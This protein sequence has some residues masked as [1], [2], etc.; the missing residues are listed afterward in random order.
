MT[1]RIVMFLLVAAFGLAASGCHTVYRTS[2]GAAAGAV[3][4]AQKDY[5]DAKKADEWMKKNLW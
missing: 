3:S 4:G 1:T 2:K 5:E